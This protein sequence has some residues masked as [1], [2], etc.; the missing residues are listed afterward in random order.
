MTDTLDKLREQCKN[1]IVIAREGGANLAL[2]GAIEAICT[3]LDLLEARFSPHEVP[4][5]PQGKRTPAYGFQ[6]P[7]VEPA[8]R[9]PPAAKQ[10]GSLTAVTQSLR[11][12]MNELKRTQE[13]DLDDLED[14]KKR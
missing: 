1:A 11:E 10:S 2:I 5:N 14:L 3:R 6:A 4:T 7:H 13:L 9:P 8:P 12:A